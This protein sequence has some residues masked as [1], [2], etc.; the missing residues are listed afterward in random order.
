VRQQHPNSSQPAVRFGRKPKSIDNGVTCAECGS[1]L[2][3]KKA[4]Y[5]HKRRV[6]SNH[7]SS[8]SR[9]RMDRRTMDFADFTGTIS[10]KAQDIAGNPA[11][12]GPRFN[13]GLPCL[14]THGQGASQL[15]TP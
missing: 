6:H 3:N 9:L 10:I 11:N 15:V 7:V 1:K 2:V 13:Q 4:L 5:Y 14:T 12:G 8:R